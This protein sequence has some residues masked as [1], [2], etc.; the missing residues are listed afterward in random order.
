ME[1]GRPTWIAV[2]IGEPEHQ[3]MFLFRFAAQRAGE[4]QFRS[5]ERSAG[6]VGEEGFKGPRMDP[7]RKALWYIEGHFSGPVGL[8]DLAEVSALSRFHLSRTFAQA[9]GTTLSA[10]LRGRRLTE[11]AR[12]L[13]LGAPDILSVALDVGYGSHEAFTRAFR[14]QF[15]VTPEEIR[16]RRSLS[17]LP[18]V[19]PIQMPDHPT[20]TLPAPLFREEGPLLLA[21]IREFRRFEDRAAIPGQW[22]RF[23]PH[24]GEIPGQNRPGTFGVCLAAAD[25]ETGFDYLTAVAVASLDELPD[26]LSGLRLSRRRYAAFPHAGHVSTIGMTCAAVFGVWQPQS[27]VRLESAPL[28]LIEAYG[29]GFDP[30]SGLGDMEVWVPTLRD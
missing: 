6:S 12:A 5:S 8:D 30:H 10:Y 13:V 18:L 29:A 9:T 28:F 2:T 27:G 20:V 21:G 3:A 1:F 16:A 25:G 4:A 15:G 23:S 24:I 11:A 22:Q 26:G 19:E 14:D 17:H 7:I